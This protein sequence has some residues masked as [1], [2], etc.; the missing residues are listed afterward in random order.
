MKKIKTIISIVIIT[1]LL[2]VSVPIFSSCAKDS[3]GINTVPVVSGEKSDELAGKVDRG[4]VGSNTDFAFNICNY[5]GV[6][7]CQYEYYYKQSGFNCYKMIYNRAG[8][9]K[10]SPSNAA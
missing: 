5:S 8:I 7:P 3:G 6:N 1:A 2:L 10:G 9:I 4:L